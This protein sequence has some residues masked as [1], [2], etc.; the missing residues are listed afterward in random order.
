MRHLKTLL[1]ALAALAGL[2]MADHARAEDPDFLTLG[3]GYFDVL[4]QQKESGEFRMEY[5][6]DYKLWF[7]HPFAGG[8]LTTDNSGYG[9][10]GLRAD[11]FLGR[12]VVFSIAEAV[13]AYIQGDGKKLGSV[14][15]FRSA[16]EVAYRF[17]DRG[18]L[19]LTIYHISNASTGS[20]NPGADVIGVFYAVPLGPG[21]PGPND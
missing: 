7:V 15:E 8:M 13:G 12:R 2:G 18:R 3:G 11:I 4:R 9:Y 16:A 6:S 5:W 21:T 19:G 1:A 14:L 10:G 17:D 20:R